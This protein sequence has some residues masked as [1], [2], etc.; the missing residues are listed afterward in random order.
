MIRSSYL[1]DYMPVMKIK[2]VKI[3]HT[4]RLLEALAGEAFAVQLYKD[5]QDAIRETI[6]MLKYELRRHKKQ[7]Q[8]R[9]MLNR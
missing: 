7:K 5:P 4:V 9:M 2:T 6:T 3:E 8:R 1:E